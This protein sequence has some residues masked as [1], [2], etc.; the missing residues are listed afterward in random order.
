MPEDHAVN[1]SIEPSHD[2]PYVVKNLEK[3]RNSK[4]EALEAK[5][6]VALCRCGGSANKPFCDGTHAEIGFSGERLTDG[7]LDRRDDYEGEGITVHDNRG[8]C[9][10]IGRCTD[11]LPSVFRLKTEPWID[12]DGAP[13]EEVVE[14]VRRCPSG[15][16]SHSIDGVE[17]RDQDREPTI[18][19]SKDGPYWVAGGIDIDVPFRAERSSLE[20]Y[21]LCRCGGSKNK[22]FCDG[23]H[24]HIGFRDEKN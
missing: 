4:G 11:G 10:H 23:T 14:T 5:P 13:V 12:P 22:P 1:P 7:G 2:G 15:A 21:A 6:T 16:L 19:V 8:I 3:L 20:H 18:T 24:S 9:A 17:H